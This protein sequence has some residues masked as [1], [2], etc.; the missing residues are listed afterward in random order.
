[1]IVVRKQNLIDGRT[2][3]WYG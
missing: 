3:S 1:M 2:R